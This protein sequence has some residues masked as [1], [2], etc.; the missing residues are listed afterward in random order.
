MNHKP[1]GIFIL[2]KESAKLIYGETQKVQICRLIDISTQIFSEQEILSDPGAFLDMEIILSGWGGPLCDGSFLS[3]IPNLKIVFY[4]AG[5]IR[6]IVSD[7][8]WERGI[9]ITSAWGGNAI[10][11]VEYTVAS[12]FFCLKKVFQHQSIYRREK[13]WIH[14]DVPG[15]YKTTVGIISLGMIGKQV[16]EKLRGYD[17]NIIAYDPYYPSEMAIKNNIKMVSLDEVF[18]SADVISLHTPWLPETERMITGHHF[19]L[20][21]EGASFINTARGA[22]VVEDEMIHILSNRPD[23]FAILDVTHPEPPSQDS[24]L[25]VMPNVL[26]TPHIAGSMGNECLRMGDI[27]VSELNRYLHDEPLEYEITEEESNKLA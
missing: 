14:L 13:R 3:L 23:L 10:P 1:K 11:V 22:I 27:M 16:V 19:S 12:I 17:L 5:S 21:K 24:P 6:G 26:L 4:G 18:L 9:R 15:A 20:M 8:F 7:K 25:F 2:D